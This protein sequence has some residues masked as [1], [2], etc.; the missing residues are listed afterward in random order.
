MG[1]LGRLAT[2]IKRKRRRAEKKWYEAQNKKFK[3]WQLTFSNRV[4]LGGDG[5]SWRLWNW[6]EKSAR[7]K[8]GTQVFDKARAKRADRISKWIKKTQRT[9]LL[10]FIRTELSDLRS[11]GGHVAYVKTED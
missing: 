7:I 3:L 10:R 9:L 8:L 5:R 4:K 2:D 6:S 11:T 1:E